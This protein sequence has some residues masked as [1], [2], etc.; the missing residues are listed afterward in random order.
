MKPLKQTEKHTCGFCCCDYL[1]QYFKTCIN[2]A[3]TRHLS[4][5]DKYPL[6]MLPT[7]FNFL[8]KW[9]IK[10]NWFSPKLKL[11]IDT[12]LYLG[13]TIVC[14]HWIILERQNNG[15]FMIYDPL[16]GRLIDLQSYKDWLII[17][18]PITKD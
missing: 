18:F 2:R 16:A 5:V 17:L 6:G 7:N 10:I 9:G 4:H 11:N 3:T 15:I 12:E 1:L 14:T 8:K 13:L